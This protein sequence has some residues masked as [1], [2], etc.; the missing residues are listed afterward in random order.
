MSVLLASLTLVMS[1]ARW[2]CGQNADRHGYAGTA[3]L[4]IAESCPPQ[5]L[6]KMMRSGGRYMLSICRSG[7]VIWA[8]YTIRCRL[9]DGLECP[10]KARHLALAPIPSHSEDANACCGGG[11]LSS[12]EGVWCGKLICILMGEQEQISLF[13]GKTYIKVLLTCDAMPEDTK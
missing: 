1:L 8:E 6:R 12:A 2:P 7:R 11:S 5:G 13:S 9:S 3:S 10:G 4:N